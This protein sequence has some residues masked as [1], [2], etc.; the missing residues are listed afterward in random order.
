M[1]HGE[2]GRLEFLPQLA[3][4]EVLVHV[5]KRDVTVFLSLVQLAILSLFESDR[6][7]SY[8]TVRSQLTFHPCSSSISC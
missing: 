1:S 6:P 7:V 8:E 3:T 4:A 2:P 5:G